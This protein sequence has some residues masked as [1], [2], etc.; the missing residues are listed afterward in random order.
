MRYRRAPRLA[1]NGQSGT[2]AGSASLTRKVGNEL[3]AGA[4]AAI[5]LS[6]PSTTM[7]AGTNFDQQQELT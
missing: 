1:K 5:L 7:H 3:R 6:Q 2:P 4:A